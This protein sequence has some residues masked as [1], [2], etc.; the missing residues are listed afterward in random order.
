[1]NLRDP[2]C[3]LSRRHDAISL[4]GLLHYAL[5]CSPCIIAYTI[6]I[7]AEKD[8]KVWD[9]GDP[10]LPGKRDSRQS[11]AALGSGRPGGDEKRNA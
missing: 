2:V 7:Q 11:L 8:W 5:I 3:V 9:S 6:H 1:M 10:L 4:S